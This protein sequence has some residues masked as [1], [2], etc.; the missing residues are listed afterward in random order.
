MMLSKLE[1]PPLLYHVKGNDHEQ[2][3]DKPHWNDQ[4]NLIQYDIFKVHKGIPI[5]LSK[6]KKIFKPWKHT[7]V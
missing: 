6:T 2:Q 3:G 4:F 5:F 1:I 7:C